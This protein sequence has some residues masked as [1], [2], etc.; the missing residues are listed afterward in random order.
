M[1]RIKLFFLGYKCP[2]CGDRSYFHE[3]ILDNW[4][5]SV[6]MSCSWCCKISAKEDFYGRDTNI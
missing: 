6:M 3:V 5:T 4:S 1:W 2:R